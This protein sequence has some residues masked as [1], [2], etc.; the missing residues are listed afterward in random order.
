[1][2]ANELRIGNYVYDNGLVHRV[3]AI[4]TKEYNKWLCGDGSITATYNGAYYNCTENEISP[5]PLT[6]EM[7]LK[8]GFEHI[9]TFTV[10]NSMVKGL[11]RGRWLSVGNVEGANQMIWL[12][13]IEEDK[14]TDLIC[15]HNFDYDG[16]ISLSKLQNLYFVLTGEELEVKL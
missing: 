14:I 11:G 4:R 10:T 9:P 6:E 15:L 3:V 13:S 1:M 2:N 12:Q 7:L 5:I 8:C 16:R